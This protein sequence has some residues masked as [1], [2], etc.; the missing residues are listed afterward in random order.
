[1]LFST[2]DLFKEGISF[3]A[4][5]NFKVVFSIVTSISY[6]KF[7]IMEEAFLASFTSITY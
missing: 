1:M 5:F 7:L 6:L 3:L 2:K 4:K